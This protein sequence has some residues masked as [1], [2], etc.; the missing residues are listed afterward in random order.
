MRF[1]E[2]HKELFDVLPFVL[3]SIGTEPQS[4]MSRPHGFDSHH[5]LWVSE[6]SGR[7]CV[8]SEKF[9]LQKGEGIFMRQEVPHSYEGLDFHTSYLTFT[10]S[11]KALDY[12]VGA[13]WFRFSF[14]SFLEKDFESLKRFA[15]GNSTIASRSAAGYSLVME[16][17][18]AT[19]STQDSI[20]N[21]ID[22]L[23]EQRYSEPLTL[24]EIA[25]F[26]GLD[27]FSLC[28]YYATARGTTVM[29][30]LLK[31]RIEKAK[32]F[33][34]YSTD[35]VARVGELCGFESPS[36]FGKRFRQTVGCTPTQ[37]RKM[38]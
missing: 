32:R 7:F 31:I 18:S 27:R 13:R 2:I 26:V 4:P 23:L 1:F 34:R 35:P 19:T 25:S 29:D 15:L 11:D 5:F 33:L 20:E 22:R 37:Y 9:T 24:D 3:T 21:R 10:L 14:P 12:L 6:G 38:F 16:L 36:Y 8:D 30:A 17:F 28:R